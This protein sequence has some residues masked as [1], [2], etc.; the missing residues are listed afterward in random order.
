MVN[1]LISWPYLETAQKDDRFWELLDSFGSDTRFLVDSGAFTNWKAHRDTRVE[2]YIA[3]IKGLPVKPWRYFTLDKIGD[4][5]QTDR[6]HQ[7]MLDAGLTP[8]PIFTRGTALE[9]LDKLYKHSDLV[10]LGVGTGTRGSLNYVRWIMENNT[11]SI[12]WLGVCHPNLLRYY[13]PYSCDS[14]SWETGGRYG[15]I[16]LY[17][18]QGRFQQFTRHMAATAPP[19]ADVWRVLES[20]GADPYEL[21]HEVNWRGGRTNLARRIGGQSWL[22]YAEESERVF[23]T[24]IFLA[25]TNG[26]ALGTLHDGWKRSCDYGYQ[27]ISVTR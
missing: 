7:S 18:G 27:P 21:R 4:S 23:G 9:E 14:S 19:S 8:V 24:L 12:H 15:R 22:R 17:M 5:T 25:L 3:F 10:G 2:D 26:N 16:S 11:R 6:N 20:Y 13:Q 1:I